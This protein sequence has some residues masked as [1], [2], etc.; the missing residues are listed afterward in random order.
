M[1]VFKMKRLYNLCRNV[2]RSKMSKICVNVPHI[3]SVQK[4]KTF[5]FITPVKRVAWLV[6]VNAAND[7]T[8]ISA[9]NIPLLDLLF[10]T[11]WLQCVLIHFTELI[12]CLGGVTSMPLSNFIK[13]VNTQPYLIWRGGHFSRGNCWMERS[14]MCWFTCWCWVDWWVRVFFWLFYTVSCCRSLRTFR[15]SPLI[16]AQFIVSFSAGSLQILIYFSTKQMIT[17]TGNLII[18]K[19]HF[20]FSPWSRTSIIYSD[21]GSAHVYSLGAPQSHY[22]RN[23]FIV[24][25]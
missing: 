6:C 24:L 19:S 13:A 12:E 4:L 16:R 20:S 9:P 25:I 5:Y 17:V 15:G 3:N 23:V 18:F 21:R 11:C 14:D 1:Y 10:L 8:N 2:Q 7:F 22:N